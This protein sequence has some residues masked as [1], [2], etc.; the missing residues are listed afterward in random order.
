MLMPAGM[1]GFRYGLSVLPSNGMKFIFVAT[2]FVW[3]TLPCV[4]GAAEASPPPNILFCIADDAS[5]EHFGANGCSWV[6][7]PNFDSVASSGIRF[8]RAYTPD[9]KCSPSRSCILT[10]RNPWQLEAAANHWPVFPEKFKTFG[11][12]L[13]ESGFDVAFAGKGWAPGTVPQGRQL[14][15][16]KISVKGK[17]PAKGISNEDY[18]GAFDQFIEQRDK[19]KPFFF[20][21]GCIEPHRKYEY[22]SG[23][24]LGGKPLDMIPKQD[25]PSCWPD[26]DAVRNDMLDYAFEIEWYD[27]H[28]GRMLATLARE[29]LL[30]NTLVVVTSDNG[31]PFPRAKGHPYELS[32]HMPL[33]MMWPKGI[34]DPGRTC[35]KLVSFIDFAPT[36]LELA[37][38]PP[39]QSGMQP[40]TGTSLLPILR[41][42]QGG[43]WRTELLQ[44]RERNDVGRPND[45]GYP[46]RSMIVG[47]LLYIHNFNSERW[48]CGNPETGFLD[49]DDSP[50]KSAVEALGETSGLWQACLGFRPA[51]ELY[52]IHKDP[53]CMNNLAVNPEHKETVAKMHDQLVA[54][55]KDEGDPRMFG[56]DDYFDQFPYASPRS[57]LY[58]KTMN[59]KDK[60]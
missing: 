11:E 31:M 26:I 6:K 5:Y 28:L 33:T 20:W 17:S 8:S 23:V 34:V 35:D 19:S 43:A 42:E 45:W 55:L 54:R 18:A 32:S 30:E 38:I 14:I 59:K 7:T 51:D 50:T 60:K 40:I 2:G 57:G 15:G 39:Q 47:N 10:G 44:G 21:F 27:Q 48:P 58:E 29:G 22:G 16:P 56:Q 9:P 53:D 49:T 36:F 13:R 25:I 1:H 37:G 46:V 52:D 3:A 41:N 12:T 24:K 4:R